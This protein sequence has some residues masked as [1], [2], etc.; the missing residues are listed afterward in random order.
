M[1]ALALSPFSLPQASFGIDRVQNRRM[2]VSFYQ[3]ASH[4]VG[5]PSTHVLLQILAPQ[6]NRHL[7]KLTCREYQS[8]IT[9]PF[10]R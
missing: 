9:T 10:K 5:R 4:G 7:Q 1:K 8:T 3:T 6:R 2:V